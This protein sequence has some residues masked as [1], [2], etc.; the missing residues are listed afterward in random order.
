MINGPRLRLR[1]ERIAIVIIDIPEQIN[2]GTDNNCD[3]TIS[4][5]IKKII[6]KLFEYLLNKNIFI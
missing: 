1:S 4:Y 2:G 3:L 6:N 5:G